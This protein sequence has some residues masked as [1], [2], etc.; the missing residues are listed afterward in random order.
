MNNS[1]FN[2][3]TLLD[4]VFANVSNPSNAYAVDTMLD[5]FNLNWSVSKQR[6][7]LQNGTE[8]PYYGI[9]RDDNSTV[10]TTCKEAYTPFQNA[11]LAEMLIRISEKTGYSIHSGGSFN[12]GAKVYLQLESPNKI[13][14]I[15]NNYDKVEGFLTGINSH[16]GST[17]LKWGE[18]NIT[19]S[20]RNTFM[21]AL[22]K[23]KSSARH[24]QSIHDKVEQAIQELNG[25]VL[26]EKSLFDQFIR[27]AEIPVQGATIAKVVKSITDVDIMDRNYRMDK[28]LS[29]YAINRTSELLAAIQ[30]EMSQKGETMWGLMSGVTQYTTHVMPTPNRD[31][32]RL[33]SLYTGKIGRAH[34]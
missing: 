27:L 21:A 20:C 7:L 25:V 23:L 15:G 8:T 17:S 28:S 3:D 33:E 6:L 9:V 12:G 32:S 4:S 31:N 1:Q 29:S 13:I 14:G 5:K 10:F 19:I 26:A 24:T 16:D 18:T 2:V 11:Q 34:V 30:K 22:K